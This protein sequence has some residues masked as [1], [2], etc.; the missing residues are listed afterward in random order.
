MEFALSVSKA[1]AIDSLF[2]CESSIDHDPALGKLELDECVRDPEKTHPCEVWSQFCGSETRRLAHSRRAHKRLRE[3]VKQKYAWSARRTT[4]RDIDSC[5]F[6]NMRPTTKDKM[7]G[8]NTDLT[9]KTIHRS[10]TAS[11]EG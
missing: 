5:D 3:R 4:L 2:F 6:G 7:L 8:C 1:T 10:A 11:C 9:G